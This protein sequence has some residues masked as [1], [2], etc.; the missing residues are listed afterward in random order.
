MFLLFGLS[1]IY[2]IYDVVF[3]CIPPRARICKGLDGTEAE[4]NKSINTWEIPPSPMTLL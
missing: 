4:H 2:A 3:Y 1:S